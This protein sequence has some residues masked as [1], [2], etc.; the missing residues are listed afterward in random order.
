MI[1]ILL[2]LCVILYNLIPTAPYITFIAPEFITDS[3]KDS[4]RIDELLQDDHK[5]LKRGNEPLLSGI[6]QAVVS[7]DSERSP[8]AGSLNTHHRISK[9]GFPPD[10]MGKQHGYIVTLGFSGQQASAM[11]AAVSQQCWAVGSFGL[12]CMLW[13]HSFA[14]TQ[15]VV[16]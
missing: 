3:I 9:S 7:T 4:E 6:R 8:T 15:L 11:Q 14:T 16:Y 1:L 10:K 12:P 5:E 13:N 2:V